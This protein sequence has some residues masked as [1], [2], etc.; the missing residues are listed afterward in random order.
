MDTGSV[1]PPPAP[2]G[3][4]VRATRGMIWSSLSL[5]T[6]QVTQLI[7]TIILM[8]LLE[9]ADF[10]LVELAGIFNSIIFIVTDLGIGSA[11]IQRKELG[12]EQLDTIYWLNIGVGLAIFAL[13]ALVLSPLVARLYSLPILRSVMIVAS[14]PLL[15]GPW[16]GPQRQLIQRNM[17]FTRLAALDI[18]SALA[19][20]IL[21]I[22]MALSGFGVW[23]IV[24]GPVLSS[25][26]GIILAWPLTSWRPQ[27][28]FRLR[29]IG[30]IMRFGSGIMGFNLVNYLGANIDFLVIGRTLG[31]TS[32]GLYTFAFDW[33]TITY[34][35]ITPFIGQVMFPT[36]SSIQD[37][38]AR[39]RRGY[40]RLLT[41]VAL[42]SFPAMAGLMVVAPEFVE[43]VFP[44]YTAAI[45]PLRILCLVGMVYSV[46]T[47][48][49]SIIMSKGKTALLFRISW[50]RLFG[51]G[52]A[53]AIGVQF[54]LVGVAIADL[55][56]SSVTLWFFQWIAGRQI[57]LPL[58]TIAR[59]L[60]SP[61][62][63]ALSMGAAT[64]AWR[65][66]LRDGLALDPG[67]TLAL[68]V[69][70]GA[71]MTLGAAWLF[72]RGEL[73]TLRHTLATVLVPYRHQLQKRFG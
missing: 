14:L 27:L 45:M 73:I 34:N 25:L 18:T 67:L 19:G 44:K 49:G 65:L 12:E 7:V 68:T 11:I 48:T 58:R 32:L 72:Q 3:L 35:R 50:I 33:G 62:L 16:G 23:S 4:A 17:R 60:A 40:L 54:G 38:D 55:I 57:D 46:N 42:I 59:T 41:Y 1:A 66:G 5:F 9:P 20:A 52:L 39:L 53:V 71:L 47:F 43:V 24:F 6:R 26:V 64:W 69:P 8:R 21:S 13:I 28:R 56:Y 22:G 30:D 70:F 10:G 15:I 36:F 61:A 37:D 51:F 63:V 2:E 31:H 29:S